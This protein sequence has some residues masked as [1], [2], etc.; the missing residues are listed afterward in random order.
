MGAIKELLWRVSRRHK[1]LDKIL[2]NGKTVIER[3]GSRVHGKCCLKFNA[4]NLRSICDLLLSYD[5]VSFD[6]FDTLISRKV[7]DPTDLFYVLEEKNGISGFHDTRIAIERVARQKCEKRNGE[8]DIFDIYRE[9]A[10]SLPINVEKMVCDEMLAEKETCYANPKMQT[11]YQLLTEKAC[12]IIAVSDM[13]L[14]SEY[15]RELLNQCGYHKIEQVFASCD[16]GVGKGNGALQKLVQSELGDKLRFIH[17]GDNFTSD[18]RG[19]EMAGW[20]A[21]WYQDKNYTQ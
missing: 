9:L 5:I 6:I 21:V 19:S 18:V 8:V 15:L 16:Y 12:R 3:M 17:V 20:R 14:P 4:H 1:W 2:R 13:Y 10:N 11:L 7:G